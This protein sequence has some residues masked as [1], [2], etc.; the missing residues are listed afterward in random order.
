[1][2][3]AIIVFS[4]QPFLFLFFRNWKTSHQCLFL[5]RARYVEN[6]TDSVI[7]NSKYSL[8]LEAFKNLI[9]KSDFLEVHSLKIFK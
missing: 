7:L 1:M 8:V 5:D 9:S 4:W 3:I 6:F 2:H